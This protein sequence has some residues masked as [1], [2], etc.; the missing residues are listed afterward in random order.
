MLEAL[1]GN[2]TAEKIFFHLYEKRR[3][4]AYEISKCCDI[5]LSMV[6][7]QL[8]RLESG[9]ILRSRFIAKKREYRWDPLWPFYRAFQR[10]LGFKKKLLREQLLDPA[11][12]SYLTIEERL[13]LG[14]SFFRQGMKLCPVKPYQPFVKSFDSYRDYEKWRKKQTH[15][16]LI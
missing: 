15:P 1:F 5:P 13:A 2:K 10:F 8:M 6:Q 11:D 16:W 4:S 9:G 14:E 7:K 12:G 3:A